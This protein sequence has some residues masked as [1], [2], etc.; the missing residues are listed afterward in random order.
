MKTMEGNLDEVPQKIVLEEIAP[1]I[2]GRVLPPVSAAERKK[3]VENMLDRRA[4]E[5]GELMQRYARRL[6]AKELKG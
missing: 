2:R 4:P 5:M 3:V 6:Y 1:G